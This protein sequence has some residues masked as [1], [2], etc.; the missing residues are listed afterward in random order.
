MAKSWRTKFTGNK[1][2]IKNWNKVKLNLN[3]IKKKMSKIS[4][5][6]NKIEIKTEI[7]NNNNSKY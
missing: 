1:I 7:K 2:E 6:E 5:D 4:K 3:F